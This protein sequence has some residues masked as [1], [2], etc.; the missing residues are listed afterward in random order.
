MCARA[1]ACVYVVSRVRKAY[2]KSEKRESET[3]AT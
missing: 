3:I 2:M 1:R